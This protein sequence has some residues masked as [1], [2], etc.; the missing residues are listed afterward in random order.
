MT[1]LRNQIKTKFGYVQFGVQKSFRYHI[2][3]QKH[4]EFCSRAASFLIIVLTVLSSYGF[5][6][7]DGWHE[8]ILPAS[9]ILISTLDLIYKPSKMIAIHRMLANQFIRLDMKMTTSPKKEDR[10]AESF[11]ALRAEIEIDEPPH[12]TVLNIM[13]HNDLW[14]AMGDTKEIYHVHWLRKAVAQWIDCPPKKWIKLDK[15]EARKQ[16]TPQSNPQLSTAKG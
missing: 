2:A 9:V 16:E 6:I 7:W 15:Y 11:Q 14:K 10:E 12:L 8:L 4:Y 1:L 5:R 13:F 3:R